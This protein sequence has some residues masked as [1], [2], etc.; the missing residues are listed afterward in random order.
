MFMK[1]IFL[2]LTLAAALFTSSAFAA[3]G[4]KSSI[5]QSFYARFHNA[6]DVQLTEVDGMIRVGFMLDGVANYA[7]YGDGGELLVVTRQLAI[8]D[9]PVSLQSSLQK[10]YAGYTIT[11]VYFFTT[12]EKSEYYVVLENSKKKITLN[13]TGN[14]WH[15]FQVKAK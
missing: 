3:D 9:L 8:N 4:K 11:D 2:A 6:K 7:Y 10:N 12:D 14:K 15:A 5:P 1:R 13:S